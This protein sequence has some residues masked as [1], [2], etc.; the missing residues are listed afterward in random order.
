MCQLATTVFLLKNPDLDAG[1]FF[2][3]FGTTADVIVSGVQAT[4]Q[5]VN[6]YMNHK[7]ITVGTLVDKTKPF[8]WNLANISKYIPAGDGGTNLSLIPKELK[9]WVDES[10]EFRDQKIEQINKYPVILV[11]S[12]G[13]LNS[14][15][16]ASASFLEFQQNM[17]QWFG[18]EGVT[19][20][21]DVKQETSGNGSK[22]DNIA[23]I[24][25][26]G[27]MNM[28]ILDQIFRNIGDLDVIDQ[29]LPLKALYNSNRYL[30]VRELVL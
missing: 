13:D 30:P 29:Y 2:I 14:N 28:G 5:G 24:M 3:R 7:A 4:K 11:I 18:W 26:F 10:V 17:R 6:K 25:Y 1:E 19:V 21:W 16:T 22:F 12:D 27:G 15:Y 23:N 20:L 9:R 8:S